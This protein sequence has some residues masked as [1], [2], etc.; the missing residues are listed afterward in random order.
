MIN[1]YFFAKL[2]MQKVSIVT[3]I[4]VC[5]LV[6]YVLKDFLC[7]FSLVIKNVKTRSKIARF[8]NRSHFEI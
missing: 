2:I 6:R 5:M 3:N 7:F 8:S 1:S 4:R